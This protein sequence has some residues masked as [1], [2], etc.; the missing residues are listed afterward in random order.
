MSGK[1]ASPGTGDQPVERWGYINRDGDVVIPPQFDRADPFSEGLA[2]ACRG[3]LEG[4]IDPTGRWVIEPAFQEIG[5]FE[6]GLAYAIRGGQWGCI[7]RSGTFVIPPTFQY[8]GSFRDGLARIKRGG[9]NGYVDRSGRLVISPRFAVA[10][11]FCECLASVG[12]TG[13]LE[14]YFVNPTGE[15]VLGPF[16][17]AKDFSEGWAVVVDAEGPCFIDAKG[18]VTLRLQGPAQAERFR[19][20]LASAKTFSCDADPFRY[21]YIDRHG[22]WVIAPT[23]DFAGDFEDGIARVE[24]EGKWGMIDREGRYVI[25]PRFETLEHLFESRAVFSREGLEGYVDGAGDVVIDASY[26]QAKPFREGLAAVCLRAG[27]GES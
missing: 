5:P 3:N 13:H 10:G 16:R 20:G 4:C 11:D 2:S 17:S 7:D 21:G 18:E 26:V 24:L 27:P 9:L 15:L 6:D 19:D 12:P 25:P 14:K 8:L 1:H 23:F 22:R